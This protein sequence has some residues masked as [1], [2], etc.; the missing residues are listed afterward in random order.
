MIRLGPFVLDEWIEEIFATAALAPQHQFLILTK[1]IT[2][3]REWLTKRDGMKTRAQAVADMAE[4][5]AIHQVRW[6]GWPLPNVWLG[7]SIESAAFNWRADVLR[8]CPAAVRWISAEPLLGPLVRHQYMTHELEIPAIANRPEWAQFAPG[9]L[10]RATPLN[11][12]GIDW[13]VAGGESGGSPERALVQRCDSVSYPKG[14]T[15]VSCF[16]PPV[17]CSAC[18]QT[19]ILPK[20]G[21][22]RWANDIREAAHHAGTSFLWKQWGGKTSKSGGRLLNGQTYDEYPAPRNVVTAP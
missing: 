20:P 9:A 1:R 7:T 14:D 5:L 19:G 22:V 17:G 3:A 12:A 2:R 10:H 4:S 16:T 11:L 8:D 21:A 18:H 6:P 13:I 15:P